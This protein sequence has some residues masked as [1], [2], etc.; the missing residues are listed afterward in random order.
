MSATR[1][2]R[3]FAVAR[4]ERA[5]DKALPKTVEGRKVSPQVQ[6]AVRASRRACIRCTPGATRRC[7]LGGGRGGRGGA[8]DTG[9]GR[10]ISKRNSDLHSQLP[11]IVWGLGVGP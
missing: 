8:A 2:T 11:T 3:R 6:T 4:G 5:E 1:V 10:A 7:G 9:E